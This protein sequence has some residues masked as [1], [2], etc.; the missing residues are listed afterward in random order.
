MGEF[1]KQHRYFN[2]FGGNTVSCEVALAVLDVLQQE[3]L[4]DNARVTGDYLKQGLL[5]LAERHP[6]IQAVRGAG[7]FLGV[8]LDGR[9]LTTRVVND[10]RREAVLIGSAG[11]NADVLKIRPPVCF[12]RTEA[13][14]FLETLGS[15]LR[16]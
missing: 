3:K 2:T 13:D 10:L 9:E 11:R 16:E 6:A 15:I 14:M 8:Q 7:L 4:V 12:G 5:T 1:A